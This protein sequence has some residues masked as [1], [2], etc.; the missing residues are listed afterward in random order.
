MKKYIIAIVFAIGFEMN[1]SAQFTSQSDGFFTPNYQE[2]RSGNAND[3]NPMG[4]MPRMI[5][6]GKTTDQ[7]AP[8]GSGLLLLSGMA[9]AYGLKK[10]E[11][12]N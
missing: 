5:G 11:S 6:H 8:L 9:L 7:D 2:L 10:K 1:L 12:K 4:A 3:D